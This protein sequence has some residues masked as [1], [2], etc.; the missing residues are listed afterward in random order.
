ME[1]M[2]RTLAANYLSTFDMPPSTNPQIIGPPGLAP[3]TSPAHPNYPLRGDAPRA[4]H[5]PS[6]NYRAAGIRTRDLFHPKE[7]RY[8]T[9]LRPV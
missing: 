3:Y 1:G 6:E 7:A 8:Q 2:I 9:A 4:L 5:F